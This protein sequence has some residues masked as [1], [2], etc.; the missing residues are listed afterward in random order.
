MAVK[1]FCRNVMYCSYKRLPR[2]WANF[3]DNPK[4]PC[5]RIMEKVVTPPGTSRAYYWKTKVV[6]YVSKA[7][8]EL[9]GIDTARLLKQFRG[10]SV[11]VMSSESCCSSDCCLPACLSQRSGLVHLRWGYL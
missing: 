11:A 8:L 9:A 7:Y 6:Y 5:A 1:L 2:G 3:S 10:E 4:T